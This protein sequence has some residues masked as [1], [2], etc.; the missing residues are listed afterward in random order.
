MDDIFIRLGMALFIGDIP[1]ER[2][3]K[4]IEKLPA[5]LGFVVALAFV[6]LAVLLEPVDESGNERGRL[7]HS[8]QSL[9][10]SVSVPPKNTPFPVRNHPAFLAR[11]ARLAV[12]IPT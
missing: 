7:T 6:G 2:L 12:F 10:V 1:P 3:E 9:C 5:K 11:H 4:R 8:R